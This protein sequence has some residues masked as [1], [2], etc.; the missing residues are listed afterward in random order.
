M[1]EFLIQEKKRPAEEDKLDIKACFNAQLQKRDFK[2]F[3]ARYWG[4]GVTFEFLAEVY[5]VMQ[6]T[7]ELTLEGR[8]RDVQIAQDLLG[9]PDHVTKFQ[10]QNWAYGFADYPYSGDPMEI[11][12]LSDLNSMAVK[13]AVDEYG[14][15]GV[16]FIYL[17]QYLVDVGNYIGYQSMPVA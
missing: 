17:E 10:T 14:S 16:A 9:A 13:M 15:G 6:Q 4:K 3:D 11:E 2:K 7:L 1:K 8:V 12:N 5:G